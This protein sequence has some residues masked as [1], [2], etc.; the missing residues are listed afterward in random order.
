MRLPWLCGQVGNAPI[1][2]NTTMINNI[3]PNDISFFLVIAPD[4]NLRRGIVTP[5]RN[6]GDLVWKTAGS[7]NRPQ[8][9]DPSP[10]M[11]T[12]RCRT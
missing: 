11:R 9:L 3:V 4:G 8:S 6:L 5:Q 10:Q 2:I 7:K 12:V 1:S